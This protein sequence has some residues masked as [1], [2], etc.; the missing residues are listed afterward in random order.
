VTY[1][2]IYA[3]NADHGY[4]AIYAEPASGHGL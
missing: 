2:D 4:H 3:I 1:A